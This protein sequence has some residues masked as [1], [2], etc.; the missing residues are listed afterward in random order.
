M[1][2]INSQILLGERIYRTISNKNNQQQPQSFDDGLFVGKLTDAACQTDSIE[3]D[4]NVLTKQIEELNARLCE[5]D[6]IIN[7]LNSKIT[8]LN[9]RVKQLDKINKENAE[10]Y[11]KLKKMINGEL[12]I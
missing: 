10:K 12:A 2:H 7:T 5:K 1:K 4:V 9:G 3:T 6:T 11:G 8:G